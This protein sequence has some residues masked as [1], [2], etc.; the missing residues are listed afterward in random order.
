MSWGIASRSGK[1]FEDILQC[2]SILINETTSIFVLTNPQKSSWSI[3][4]TFC[5]GVGNVDISL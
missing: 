3:Y 2:I 1:V 5:V 4:C